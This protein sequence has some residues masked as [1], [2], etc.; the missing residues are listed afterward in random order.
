M[1]VALALPHPL[2]G[3]LAQGVLLDSHRLPDRPGCNPGWVILVAGPDAL[4]FSTHMLVAG[5][6]GCYAIAGHYDMPEDEAREDY[7]Q[8]VDRGTTHA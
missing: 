5:E 8:R 7:A 2:P 1:P 3:D 6:A 4:S